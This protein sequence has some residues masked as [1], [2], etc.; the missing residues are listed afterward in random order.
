MSSSA[1][2]VEQ[3][4]AFLSGMHMFCRKPFDTMMLK[5][6]LKARSSTLRLSDTLQYLDLDVTTAYD[7]SKNNDL[8]S[9]ES[10]KA[11]STASQ[12]ESSDR[13]S[14][15]GFV[16]KMLSYFSSNNSVVPM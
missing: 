3:D 16:S 2:N 11:I 12:I 7:H 6:I 1:P 13:R 15:P 10:I 9:N 4:D 8:K 5:R 14:N